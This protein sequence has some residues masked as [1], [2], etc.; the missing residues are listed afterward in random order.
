MRKERT[1]PLTRRMR[2]TPRREKRLKRGRPKGSV[3]AR[4]RANLSK[5]HQRRLARLLLM[6]MA[7]M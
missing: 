2:G 5:I 7:W 1:A 3:A 4:G 6:M